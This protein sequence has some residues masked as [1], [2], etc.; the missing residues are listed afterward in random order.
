MRMIVG[1]TRI[2]R[3]GPIRRIVAGVC[4]TSV[5]TIGGPIQIRSLGTSFEDVANAKPAAA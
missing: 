3:S 4:T 2:N 5:V 1:P